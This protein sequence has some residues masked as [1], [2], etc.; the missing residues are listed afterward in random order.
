MKIFIVTFVLLFAGI[1]ITVESLEFFAA[2]ETQVGVSSMSCGVSASATEA[3]ETSLSNPDGLPGPAPPKL[4][5]AESWGSME[6]QPEVV[7]KNSCNTHSCNTNSCENTWQTVSGQPV[8]NVAR[9]FHN[10]RPIRRLLSKL[11]FWG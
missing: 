1:A 2:S 5:G 3:K 9:F 7:D 6:K 4:K 8:R 10:R 11:F